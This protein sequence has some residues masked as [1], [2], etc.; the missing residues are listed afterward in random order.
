MKKNLMIILNFVICFS[1]NNPKKSIY[2][3][4]VNNTFII[5]PIDT[6]S[7]SLNKNDF[8]DYTGIEIYCFCFLSEPPHEDE[9]GNM[10]SNL[11]ICTTP[12]RIKPVHLINSENLF[13]SN[14]DFEIVNSI[15]DIFFREKEIIK[16]R[17]EIDTRFLIL[18]KKDGLQSDTLVFMNNR[19]FCYNN[20]YQLNYSFNVMDS[21]KK[22]LNMKKIKCD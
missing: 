3:K 15:R 12:F 20:T 4:P 9:K 5:N 14:N 6:A 19:Q 17:C 7:L 2:P 11:A 10:V 16:N 21:I 18:L 1:C 22:R 8:T 13:Y